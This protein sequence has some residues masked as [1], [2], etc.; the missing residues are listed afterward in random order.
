MKYVYVRVC[1][2]LSCFTHNMNVVILLCH[3]YERS[4]LFIYYCVLILWL[5]TVKL[6]SPLWNK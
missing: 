1:D 5:V 3:G 2:H 6:N 4:H